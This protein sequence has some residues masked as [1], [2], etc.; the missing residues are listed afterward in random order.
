MQESNSCRFLERVVA[1][2]KDSGHRGYFQIGCPEASVKTI[3]TIS[4]ES[5]FNC[6]KDS[7]V[8]MP[9]GSI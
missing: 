8:V 9:R 6:I 7:C 2:E 3:N 4:G 1:Q 5:L